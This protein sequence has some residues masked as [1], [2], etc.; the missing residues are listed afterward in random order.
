MGVL[1]KKPVLRRHSKHAGET[2][3]ESGNRGLKSPNLRFGM[4]VVRG[5]TP[6]Y[7][8]DAWAMMHGYGADEILA[9]SSIERLLHPADR[10][11]IATYRYE[12]AAGRYA[13]NRYAYRALRK[14]GGY[15]WV[16]V[17]VQTIEW[18]GEPADRF[19]IIGLR[20]ASGHIAEELPTAQRATHGDD[21]RLLAVIDQLQ[22]GC[23]LYDADE[24]LVFFNRRYID[25][26]PKA[27]IV[28]QSGDRF[29]LLIRDHVRYGRIKDA[30][31]NEE[32]W[33]TK[34]LEA[35][36]APENL[37]IDIEYQH[38]MI[39][40]R[41]IKTNDGGTL[42]ICTD[43]TE[44]RTTARALNTYA[45][46]IDQVVDR[47]SIV[48]KDYRYVFVNQALLD[49]YQV[50]KSDLIGQH[51]TVII[52][53]DQ[54]FRQS[55]E[56]LDRCFSG[57]VLSRPRCQ[58]D[59]HG[60]RRHF[61][62][63]LKPYRDSGGH[64]IGAISMMR[65][66]T[67][68]TEYRQ[69]LQMAKSAI[70]Q[71]SERVLIADREEKI[72]F[73]NQTNLSFY[74]HE[75]E[76]VLGRHISDLVG[77]DIYESYSRPLMKRV[78]DS[79]TPI[80]VEYWLRDRTGTAQYWETSV[81]P[82]READ[83]TISGTIG[84][85]RD[86]TEHRH[87][88]REK[89]RFQDAIEHMSDCYALFDEEERVVA[90]NRA[91][92]RMHAPVTPGFGIGV[93]FEHIIR[94]RVASGEILDAIGCEEEWINKRLESFRQ[95]SFI[96]DFRVSGGLWVHV[97][98]RRTADGGILLMVT[99]VTESKR[100]EEALAE[101][102]SRFRDFSKLASDWF[103]EQDADGRYTYVSESIGELTKQPVS[104]LLGKTSIEVFGRD[105]LN[106]PFWQT[107]WRELQTTGVDRTV[108]FEHDLESAD[109]QVFRVRSV[110]R[111]IKNNADVIIGYRGAAK[112][113]TAAHN[114]E[115]KL[116]YEANHDAL[117]GL[118]NR[119]SFENHLLQ[120]IRSS[121]AGRRSSAFCFIDLDQFKIVNDTAGHLAG[122]R[123]L[124]QVAT[125]LASKI[126]PGDVL[127]RIGGDE[128]G[129]LLQN[130]SLRRAQNMVKKLLAFLN[131]NRFFHNHNVFEIGASI[132]VTSITPMSQGDVSQILAEADLA[133][134]AA[135]DEGRNR[136]QVYR[137]DDRQLNLR[138]EEMSKAS[139]IRLAL[140]QDRFA[141][142]TQP[143]MP[144][145]ASK[146]EG[147]HCE[148]LLRMIEMDGSLSPPDSFIP[149]AELYGLMVQ[150]DRWVIQQ[151]FAAF[152]ARP[153]TRF[154]IN[155]SGLSLNEGGLVGLIKRLLRATSI[156]PENV[157]FEITETAAIHS[158]SKTKALIGELK[159]IG[160]RFA[161]DDFGSG[162]SS[163]NY[164]KQLPVD[165]LK[166]DGSFIRDIE[167]DERNRTMV[168][169]IHQVA[170]SLNLKTVA[171]CVETERDVACLRAIGI[172][173]IQGFAIGKPAPLA[174]WSTSKKAAV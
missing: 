94:G 174:N 7:V 10:L 136:V 54:F 58:Y 48:D 70:D 67:N 140:D 52:G 154:N 143:I 127:A 156:Q 159:K 80:Q 25:Y 20:D 8:S 132:G 84:T 117:T 157:C 40:A 99:D 121:T 101:S 55:K 142:F 135:K 146:Q 31:G 46:V 98:N 11:R 22:D 24:R 134:Y 160:C 81:V 13:P 89:Q 119:R 75:K 137:T 165:Y 53:E 103:W 82:Y 149:A 170:R 112:N 92:E 15:H 77:Q 88:E 3:R 30:I 74:N 5:E 163:F 76:Q 153:N 97:R 12:R 60:Q 164:L 126:R 102:Q 128:F 33:I 172:D 61:D 124:Q 145:D 87:A 68:A 148:I 171:E 42:L 2:A 44:A 36:R 39:R 37:S 21:Q 69:E 49:F 57:E 91:Y 168:E 78:R 56:E 120:A 41:H 106:D 19:K 133:C 167:T 29:E 18:L 38:R 59:S 32:A 130:C 34:R 162:L 125:L 79:G 64:I 26:A 139:M 16:D 1:E 104:E 83:G 151:S 65:D 158:L 63:S 9:M 129:L 169:A 110:C 122:D 115:R 105:I 147:A 131:E 62:L 93:T 47:I 114:L 123:L 107:L 100:I 152:A 95:D 66:V 90:F 6:L 43:L 4:I 108:E 113:V 27:D 111:P 23:A 35:F 150:I 96:A 144:L 161:L 72:Q 118:L 73:I 116:E 138:R 173:F 50:T 45:S 14:D 17:A 109:G 28:H 166:I 155:L 85:S 141:L 71:I 86:V 51:I